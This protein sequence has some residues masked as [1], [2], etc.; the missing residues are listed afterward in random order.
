MGTN[1]QDAKV[2]EMMEALKHC[3]EELNKALVNDVPSEIKKAKEEY[4]KIILLAGELDGHF[5]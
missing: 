1:D 3:I 4:A 5:R 2:E